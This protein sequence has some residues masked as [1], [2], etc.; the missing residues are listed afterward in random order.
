MLVAGL[1]IGTQSL[2]VVIADEGLSIVGEARVPYRPGFPHPGWAEQ[3]S[4][5]WLHALRVA[6]GRALAAAGREA[7]DIGGLAIAGQL[8]GCVPVDANGQALAPA[9]IWMDRR[10][11]AAVDA[12]SPELIRDRAG[13]VL[14]ATHMA[15][16]ICWYEA[17]LPDPARIALW[18]QPVSFVVEALTGAR[19]YDPALAST[20]M[21]YGLAACAYDPELLEAF[22]I[23]PAKLPAI[24]PATS[25]AGLLNARGAELSGLPVGL[26]V[27]VGTGDDFANMLGGGIVEPGVVGAVLGTG[28]VVGALADSPIVDP[29]LL[30]ETHAYFGGKY[31]I[32]NPGWLGGG[33]VS[34]FNATF[35][36]ESP[37]VFSA[38]AGE[39]PAGSDGLL[40]LPALQGA[41]APRWVPEARGA[42]YGL[43]SAHDKAHCARAVMEGCA[44]A[45]FDVIERLQ[46]LGV[47][48]GKLRLMGGGAKSAVWT[49]IRADLSGLPTEV[50]TVSDT[51]ALGAAV[52]ASVAAGVHATVGDAVSAMPMRLNRIEPDAANLERYR[53]GHARYRKL[54]AALEPMYADA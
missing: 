34:W 3:D 49:R 47:P 44:F 40:F 25:V 2:K 5:L 50:S 24:A 36:V 21:L 37:A 45:M 19:V 28:E 48:V 20:T 4:R 52:L 27:A 11:T 42:F 54:F 33:S 26:P 7:S 12:H 10:A 29:D 39:A 43:S 8:D 16:K 46:S 31:F 23:D 35:G 14:D 53:A 51:S 32:E 30:V 13:L 1:D 9:I 15:A 18:H 17:N 38:L 41:M 22:G 6:I